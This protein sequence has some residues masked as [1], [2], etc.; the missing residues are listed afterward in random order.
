M[1]KPHT[2]CTILFIL[3][4]SFTWAQGGDSTRDMALVDRLVQLAVKNS[5]EY[6]ISKHNLRIA[7]NNIKLS[8]RSWYDNF[9]ITGNANEFV[10]NPSAD[11]EERGAFFPLYNI[12]GNLSVGTFFN[13]PIRTRIEKEKYVIAQSEMKIQHSDIKIRVLQLYEE[14]LLNQKLLNIQNE[15]MNDLKAI[16][17]VYEQKFRD[18]E[19]SFEA[20]NKELIG[21]NKL[22]LEIVVLESKLNNT[23]I[24]LESMIG[25]PIEEVIQ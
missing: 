7:R 4:F 20:Y 6:D 10:L 2:F 8:R 16:H 12:S 19:I 21:H 24:E 22:Q 13:I 14:Y 3:T 1:F 9:N 25:V 11:A 15:I 18:E 23:L 5:A 17:T